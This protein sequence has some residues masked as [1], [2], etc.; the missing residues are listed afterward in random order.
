MGTYSCNVFCPRC[1]NPARYG[2]HT[3]LPK[4]FL[5]CRFCGYSVSRTVDREKLVEGQPPPKPKK[6]EYKSA[7]ASY[8]QYKTGGSQCG[9]V[10]DKDNGPV[11]WEKI[12]HR[13][14]E[15]LANPD[16]DS[17]ESYLTKWDDENKKVINL[18]GHPKMIIGDEC[19]F[20]CPEK[21]FESDGERD[22][23]EWPD[24]CPKGFVL[25]ERRPKNEEGKN[26]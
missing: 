21:C 12:I 24:R 2:C 23:K 20:K 25:K 9:S 6:H 3:R 16:V 4:E 18:I 15:I 10:E 13:F 26:D 14:Q 8:I 22:P 17:Q 7:G 5:Y 19:P 1:G 11:D